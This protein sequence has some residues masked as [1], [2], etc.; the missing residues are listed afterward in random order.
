M[1]S[2]D[3]RIAALLAFRN[4]EVFMETYMFHMF[5]LADII[6]GFDDESTDN[7]RDIFLRNG[8]VLI[9]NIFG[10]IGGQGATLDI[11]EHL[12]HEGR[13]R[14]YSKFIVLDCDEVIITSKPE[15]LK[16]QIAELK[17]GS[18]LIMKWIMSD[19]SGTG[20]LN[21]RSVWSPKDK[22]FAFADCPNMSYPTDRKF[23]HFS[24]TPLC[25][26]SDS[27]HLFVEPHDAFVLHFQF[28]NWELGQI[29]QCW[30]RL[31]EVLNLGRS[32]KVVNQTYQFTK[33]P[34]DHS[35][36]S[37]FADGILVDFSASA[38]R[39]FPVNESWYFYDIEAKLRRTKPFRV[40]NIDI[41]HLKVMQELY[42]EVY[43]RKHSFSLIANHIERWQL[44]WFHFVYI[45]RST[46]FKCKKTINRNG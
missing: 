42:F 22:D 29:K 34:P 18:K 45:I 11:R 21:E 15:I 14:G 24:R 23:V 19:Q 20:Y 17:S 9:P 46:T 35:L 44:R 8:G 7:S 40:R 26:V 33:E 13:R 16:S 12:L 31:H 4:E 37:P 38:A 28:L 32:S 39:L 6:L 25:Q 30:Y 1:N 2:L 27:P 3:S 36:I 5:K 43:G 41:W 10:R